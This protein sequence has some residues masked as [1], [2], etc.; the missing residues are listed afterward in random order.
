LTTRGGDEFFVRPCT[1]PTSG[2]FVRQSAGQQRAVGA[3]NPCPVEGQGEPHQDYYSRSSSQIEE[4]G[5]QNVEYFSAQPR[6]ARPREGA[7]SNETDSNKN[8]VSFSEK[9]PSPQLQTPTP[10]DTLGQVALHVQ[11]Q[12]HLVLRQLPSVSSLGVQEAEHL[13]DPP[14]PLVQ[15][16]GESFC[17]VRP[18]LRPLPQAL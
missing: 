9:E 10:D 11:G 14:P 6:D 5:S 16:L 12:Q 2:Q 7:Q 1:H 13:L 8:A 15:K 18:S 3:S 4:A 17:C